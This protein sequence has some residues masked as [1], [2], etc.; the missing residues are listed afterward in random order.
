MQ[1]NL[2]SEFA[3]SDNSIDPKDLYC[4]LNPSS[5]K[6]SAEYS[7]KSLSHHSSSSSVQLHN[8]CNQYLSERTS[9]YDIE[10]MSMVETSIANQENN[11]LQT[12]PFSIRESS[13]GTIK[14]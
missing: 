2:I 5:V 8:P 1:D 14:L 11:N 10:S 7:P 12:E 4:S 6:R 3:N 9:N 13:Q